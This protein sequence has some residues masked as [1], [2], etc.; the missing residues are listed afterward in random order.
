M[1]DVKLISPNEQ[2][3]KFVRKISIFESKK[4]IN[5][6][7]KLTPSV[8]TILSYNHKDIPTPIIGTHQAPHSQRLQIAGPKTGEDIYIDYDGTL[9]QILIEF[10][11]T[12]FYY[13]FHTSPSTIINK[14]VDFKKLF[15]TEPFQLEPELKN[16]D[17][18]FQQIKIIEEWLLEKSNK[19]LSFCDY[20][21][22]AV[23]IM[24]EANG[25][26]NIA[27]LSD[28]IFKSERQFMRR[29]REIVGISPKHFSKIIQ[30]HYVINLMHK[31]EYG[32]IQDLSYQA[33]FY[34][35]PSFS[36]KFKSL[37]GFSP[38]EFIESDDHI[39]LKYFTDLT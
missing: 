7:Q 5:Y 29:F 33:N 1:I 21:D 36:N 22:N 3:S 11:A 18:K 13:L 19:A 31:K 9:S 38:S 35:A 10:S 12:G 39:A 26:I 32:S 23:K 8:Y 6:R 4:E 16:L 14:I 28:Q 34:D 17:D 30:L 27:V 15:S 24:E 37:T 20:I 25:S 2:L